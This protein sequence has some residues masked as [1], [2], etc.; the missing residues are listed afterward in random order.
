MNEKFE[1]KFEEKCLKMKCKF[2]K[3]DKEWKEYYCDKLGY[4][5][6]E[7]VEDKIYCDNL[8]RSK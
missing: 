2:L 3:F 6:K 5:L 1:E 7:I 4:F 8:K